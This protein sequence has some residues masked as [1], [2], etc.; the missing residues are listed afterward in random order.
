M[1]VAKEL[2]ISLFE[3]RTWPSDEIALWLAFFKEQNVRNEKALKQLQRR[4]R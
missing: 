3:V 2:G 1:L 4:K